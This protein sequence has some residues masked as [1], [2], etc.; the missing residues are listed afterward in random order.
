MNLPAGSLTA[1][2]QEAI[3][4]VSSLLRAYVG[5]NMAGIQTIADGQQIHTGLLT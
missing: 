4:V 1:E 3:K 2:G 5:P